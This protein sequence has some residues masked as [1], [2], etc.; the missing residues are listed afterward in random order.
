MRGNAMYNEE[1]EAV[2]DGG[3]ESKGELG[4]APALYQYFR[5]I[6]AHQTGGLFLPAF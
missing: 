4:N 3:E 2:D 6:H 5:V 1:K